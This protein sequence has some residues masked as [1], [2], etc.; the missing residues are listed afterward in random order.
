MKICHHFFADPSKLEIFWM[1][2]VG[3]VLKYLIGGLESKELV[4]VRLC[5]ACSSLS[6]IFKILEFFVR[7]GSIVLVFVLLN[8]HSTKSRPLFQRDLGEQILVFSPILIGLVLGPVFHAR[9]VGFKG[10]SFQCKTTRG[11]NIFK[12]RSREWLNAA[13]DS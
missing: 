4:K 11:K 7:I 12:V 8:E 6:T 1:G 3:Q 5:S 2:L 9:H 13:R 10:I